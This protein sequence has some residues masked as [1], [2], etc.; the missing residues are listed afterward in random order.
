MGVMNIIDHGEWE[1]YRP[2]KYPIKLPANI[3]FARRV[4]DGMDWYLF[5]RRELTSPDTVKM[6]LRKADQGL[7][8]I[9]TTRDA[10][11]LFPAGSRLIE[12]SE[13]SGDHEALRQNLVDIANR[14]FTPPPLEE[15]RVTMMTLLMEEL[16]LDEKQMFE[17]LK[18]RNRSQHG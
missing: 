6:L 14:K 12:V 5:H 3:I 1:L 9:T 11:E 2:E 8:V 17:K 15:D 18:A 10:S 7:V 13:V 4:S 16:G